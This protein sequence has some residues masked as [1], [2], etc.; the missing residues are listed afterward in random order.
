MDLTTIYKNGSRALEQF[1]QPG[2]EGSS[3][4]FVPGESQ[5]EGLLYES[6]ESEAIVSDERT[7]R[8]HSARHARKQGLRSLRNKRRHQEQPTR[9]RAERGNGLRSLRNKPQRTQRFFQDEYE[10]GV[11]EALLEASDDQAF[12][13]DSIDSS[14]KGRRRSGR[15]VRKRPIVQDE[16][17]D[18]LDLMESEASDDEVSLEES[19]DSSRKSRHRRP[20]PVQKKHKTDHRKLR[21]IVAWRPLDEASRPKDKQDHVSLEDFDEDEIEY[22][23]RF[24]GESYH[25]AQWRPGTWLIEN[26]TPPMRRAYQKKLHPAVATTEDAI[27]EEWLRIEICLDVE[28]TSY[29]PVGDDVEVDLA[30]MPEVSQAYVKWRGLGYED[31]CWEE[32]PSTDETERYGLWKRAYED[33]IFGQYVHLPKSRHVDKAKAKP[34]EQLELKKQPGYLTGGTLMDYQ[35]EG[36]NWLYF[37]WW[38][39]QNA[40]LADEMGLGKTIQV[41]SFLAILF[42]EQKVWPF[43]VV[44]PHSTVPNWKREIQT[45]APGLRVVTYFGGKDAR[46]IQREYE[47]FHRGTKDLKCHVVVTSYTCPITDSDVLRRIPWECLVVDEGQRLKNDESLLYKELEKYKKFRHKVLLTGTP[48]QNSPRELFNLLQFLDPKVKAAEMEEEFGELTNEN[49]PVLHSLIRPFFLRRTKTQVLTNLPPMA[50]VI[51]PVS[52]SALQRKLYKS[53]LAK[54]PELIKNILYRGNAKMKQT[55]RAKLNNLL[56]QLRKCVCHPFLYNGDI[57][58]KVDDPELLHRNLVEAGSKLGLLNLLLPKLRGRGHRV[59]L[60][61]Q[62]LGMLDIVEDFL[63]TLGFSHQRI[64]GSVS[65]LERQ[66]RI[67]AYNAPNSPDF[68]FLL[69]TGAGGVGIN[70]ATADTVIILDPDFNP[71][72][73]LQSLSRAHRIGQKNKVLVFHLITRDTAEERIMQIGKKKLS[74]DHLIIEKMGAAE[75]EGDEVDVESILKFGAAKLFD[76]DAE[77]HNIQYDD[78]S[79]DKLLDRSTIENT[80]DGKAKEGGDSSTETAFSFARVWANDKGTLEDAPLDDPTDVDA[81]PPVDFWQKIIQEREAEA[82]REAAA[83]AEE[84]ARG[85]RRKQVNY[86]EDDRKAEI[87]A[88]PS[89]RNKHRIRRDSD[90]DFQA[91]SSAS[92]P[93]SEAE[94]LHPYE[95]PPASPPLGAARPPSSTFAPMAPTHFSNTRYLAGPPRNATLYPPPTAYFAGAPPQNGCN[96]QPVNPT[97]FRPQNGYNGPPINPHPSMPQNGVYRGPPINPSFGLYGAP[98]PPPRPS[99]FGFNPSVPPLNTICQACMSF[100]P[101]GHCHRQAAS[102]QPLPQQQHQQQQPCPACRKQHPQGTCPLRKAG[103]QRCPFCHL[104]HFGK[105]ASCPHF[106]SETQMTAMLEALKTSGEDKELVA[107]AKSFLTGKKA[108]LARSKRDKKAADEK[109]AKETE[110]VVVD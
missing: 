13:D 28:Y 5:D 69:S 92:E 35:K 99:A 32:P 75:E 55:E 2:D 60:F 16:D 62:F 7:T 25:K 37:T 93:D 80:A 105:A 97:N 107:K 106:G 63:N 52:M 51:L 82:A 19:F 53:I 103:V 85:R 65:S 100:H 3:E 50:V 88:T 87:D 22:L 70:L 23:I 18:D 14:R 4:N 64:D 15:N 108:S 29:V 91:A 38:K 47:M 79:I 45:W 83:R 43:L 21:N 41:L 101:P 46:K 86:T 49:V 98:P 102:F 81:P 17:E 84:L 59:L 74:M 56:M 10:D 9:E 89:K 71:H 95:L 39:G 8:T 24:D 77:I 40:I 36:M 109:R 20:L 1:L 54:D 104:Y 90:T 33:Y 67:D 30:R 27:D 73:D 58:E 44:V 61:S 6:S 31:A 11:D 94:D 26:S 42:E 57:E 48:L 96:G 72:R 34:F 66:K 12:L 68:A 76:D 110:V 78:A